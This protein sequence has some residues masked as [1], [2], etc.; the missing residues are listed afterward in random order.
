M[1]LSDDL[2]DHLPGHFEMHG[3]IHQQLTERRAV[4]LR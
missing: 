3:I 2:E 4:P 1:I